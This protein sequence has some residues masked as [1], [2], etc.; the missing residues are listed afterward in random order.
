M[1]T[2]QVN[3]RKR[4]R[5]NGVAT[6]SALIEWETATRQTRIFVRTSGALTDRPEDRADRGLI[7]L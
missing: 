5:D 2:E 3:E 7:E 4:D 6:N 1:E